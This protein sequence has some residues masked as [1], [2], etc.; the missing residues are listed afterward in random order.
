MVYI[1]YDTNIE[2][3]LLI[4]PVNYRPPNLALTNKLQNITLRTRRVAIRKFCESRR[5][6]TLYVLS[7]YILVYHPDEQAKKLLI[8]KVR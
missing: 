3:D 6:E 8:S 2:L 4:K 1:V 7:P 5:V